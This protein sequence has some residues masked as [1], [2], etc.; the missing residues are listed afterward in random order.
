MTATAETDVE[1]QV[2]TTQVETQYGV[3]SL[4]DL[5]KLEDAVDIARIGSAITRV[6]EEIAD[7]AR[8]TRDMAGLVAIQPFHAVQ[9]PYDEAIAKIDA[10][11]DADKIDSATAENRRQKAREKRRKGME[12]VEY[13]P[14]A[15][16]RDAMGISR[17][18]FAR[19]IRRAP[20][21]LPDIPNAYEVAKAAR[22][23]CELYDAINDQA[24]TI[25]DRAVAVLLN[26]DA[27]RGIQPISNADVARITGLTTA[28]V[29]QMRYGR[30]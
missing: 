5:S 18:M 22:V 9:R 3:F 25:R 14:A 28:R 16:W 21:V 26:G 10:A 1:D 13:K 15:V 24:R 4:D 30:R 11:L 17:G 20:A 2:R 8:S 23:E 12:S 7:T 19:L 6:T 27:K 29:A